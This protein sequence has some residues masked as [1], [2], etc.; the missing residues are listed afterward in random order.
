MNVTCIE[1]KYKVTGNGLNYF[2]TARKELD[3]ELTKK[4][5]HEDMELKTFLTYYEVTG[6]Q[7][8]EGPSQTDSTYDIINLDDAK[9][10]VNGIQSNIHNM[11]QLVKHDIEDK[12]EI[13][14]FPSVIVRER[15]ILDTM[16]REFALED[17]VKYFMEKYKYHDI[18]YAKERLSGT[19][20]K[21][22]H[23]NKVEI[24]NP[25]ANRRYR[26]YRKLVGN[27]DSDIMIDDQQEDSKVSIENK[28]S[29]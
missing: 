10:Y 14:I 21:M 23:E 2:I 19:L 25:D 28:G 13:V 27:I 4:L 29:Q 22:K 9:T 18:K 11:R 16:P 3:Q 17:V 5:L 15:M 1:R 8:D 20:Q 24:I 26:K 7:K 6:F 12:S